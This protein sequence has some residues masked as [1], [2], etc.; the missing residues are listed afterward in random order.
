MRVQ[1]D[2]VCCAREKRKRKKVRE[3]EREREKER[4]REGEKERRRER[5]RVLFGKGKDILLYCRT[6]KGLGGEKKKTGQPE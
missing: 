2:T 5:E 1:R 3:R 4:R 6:S